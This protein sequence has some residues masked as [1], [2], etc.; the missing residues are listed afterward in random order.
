LAITHRFI[1]M[2]QGTIA[3]ES[4]LGQG[5]RFKIQLPAEVELENLEPGNPLL[6]TAS[7]VEPHHFTSMKA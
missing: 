4:K 5:S 6:S 2:M 1:Q 3:V 7:S